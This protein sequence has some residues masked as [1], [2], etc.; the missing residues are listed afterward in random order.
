[1]S[2]DEL[3]ISILNEVAEVT[4]RKRLQKIAFLLKESGVSCNVRFSML[5]YGPFSKE[6][7][8]ATEQLCFLGQ[9]EERNERAGINRTFV[10]VYS[11]NRRPMKTA[12]KLSN[13][14]SKFLL[15]MNRYSTIELEVA[16][17]I[18]FL[19][20]CGLS[21]KDAIRQTKSMKPIKSVPKV[22]EHSKRIL[23]ALPS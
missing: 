8:K 13:V 17:T 14:H 3:I 7:A 10:T 9:I 15:A 22:I 1:M 11:L 21:E 16:A 6:I 19:I 12:T 18:R 23:E 2:P 4:G 5:D 20:R